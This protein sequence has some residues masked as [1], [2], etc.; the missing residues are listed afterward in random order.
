MNKI[1]DYFFS[2]FS[3]IPRVFKA[4]GISSTLDSLNQPNAKYETDQYNQF[5][6]SAKE[7]KPELRNSTFLEIDNTSF[8]A[9]ISLQGRSHIAS[10][11]PCQDYHTIKNLGQGWVLSIISDGAGSAK[12]SARGSKA[13]CEITA[14]LLEQLLADKRWIE[15][16]YMPSDKEWDIEIRNVFVTTKQI[17]LQQSAQQQIEP[18]NFNATILLLLVTPNGMLSAHIGDGRM[19][20]KDSNNVWYSLCTPHKGDEACQTVFIPNNWDVISIPAYQVSGVYLPETSV[21][22]THP[23]AFVL[24]SDGCEQAMWVCHVYNEKLK[25]NEDRNIPYSKFLDPLIIDIATK[26]GEVQKID[27]L[28][29][30]TSDGTQVC[31]NEQDD[32]SI[33][34]G[35]L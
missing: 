10:K 21:I 15:S 34:V 16:N 19:G 22:N 33:I 24:I 13:T 2:L 8:V 5:Y 9:G 12:E 32:R 28:I 18:D 23:K 31:K 25:K 1:I 27:R 30:I 6:D 29:F 14:K 3:N 26:E 7:A 20:Y 11:T 4:R 35:V 17:I